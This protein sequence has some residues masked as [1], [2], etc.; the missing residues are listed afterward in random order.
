ML[1]SAANMSPKPCMFEAWWFWFCN[2]NDESNAE[3]WN[4]QT[5]IKVMNKCW[6]ACFI[7]LFLTVYIAFFSTTMATSLHMTRM[8]PTH[9]CNDITESE[10]VK[11]R[12][13]PA[14]MSR[15]SVGDQQVRVGNNSKMWWTLC[16]CCCCC[17]RRLSCKTHHSY[18]INF[19]CF[20]R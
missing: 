18:I 14:T 3:F 10:D 11:P 4:W 19:Y 7:W 13:R 9:L 16:N 5:F 12:E 20:A 15:L 2:V 1:Y 6:L 8:S 17:C